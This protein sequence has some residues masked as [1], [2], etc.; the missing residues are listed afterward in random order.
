MTGK[1]ATVEPKLKADVCGVASSFVSVFGSALGMPKLNPPADG[2][3]G[4][5]F[6]SSVSFFGNDE[7]VDGMPKLNVCVGAS[8][9]GLSPASSSSRAACAFW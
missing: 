8:A 1:E 6:F 3:T 7:A 2:L 5:T 9:F 4:S